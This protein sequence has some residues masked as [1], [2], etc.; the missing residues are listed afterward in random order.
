MQMAELMGLK[1]DNLLWFA[2]GVL[3]FLL[4]GFSGMTGALFRKVFER[5]DAGFY[6][7]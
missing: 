7:S 4:G 5:K 6:R 3:G 2:T 1:N